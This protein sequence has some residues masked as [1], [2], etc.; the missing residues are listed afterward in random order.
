MAVERL[1]FTGEEEESSEE[2]APCEKEK[3]GQKDS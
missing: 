3:A 2:T 1:F